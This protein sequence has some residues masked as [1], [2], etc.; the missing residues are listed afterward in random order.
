MFYH[1]TE[2]HRVVLQLPLLLGD[3]S[4]EAVRLDHY[5]TPLPYFDRFTTYRMLCPRGHTIA[6]FKRILKKFILHEKFMF[7]LI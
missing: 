4:P 1:I 2:Y 3:K 5:Q 6:S 7:Y